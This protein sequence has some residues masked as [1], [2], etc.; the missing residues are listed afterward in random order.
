MSNQNQV[1]YVPAGTGPVYWGPGD[2]MTFLITGAQTGGAFFL[3]EVSVPPEGGPPPHIHR[4]EDESFYLLE[5]TLMV[6][7]GEKSLHVSPGDF[8]HVPRGTPHCFKNIGKCNARLL[9]TVTP[10]GLEKFF[11]ETFDPAADRSAAP[12][13]ASEAMIAR[14]VAAAPRYGLEI[15]PPAESAEPR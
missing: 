8:V 15:V 6:Q 5:G 13:P 10:A 12:P 4:R 14:F 11:E 7:A 3:A 1:K 2:Q 9:V